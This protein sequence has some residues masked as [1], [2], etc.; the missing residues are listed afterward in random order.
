V[1]SAPDRIVAAPAASVPA[2]RAPE[3]AVVVGSDYRAL[4]IVRSLG[5]K[6]VPV[7]VLAAGDDRLAARSR[8]AA[9]SSSWPDDER[10]RVELLEELV[11]RSPHGLA[12]FSS[13]D[14]SAAWVARNHAFLGR[15][16]TLTTPSWD[17]LRWSYD[18][19]NT[20]ELA[21]EA[22]VDYPWTIYPRSRAE[23]EDLECRFPVVLKPT[24]K[25][26][27]N[28][29]TAAKAW[30]V[31]DREE[32]LR[33]YDE[34]AGLVDPDTLMV[35]EL[36]PGESDGQFSYAALTESGRVLHSIV[37][38]RTRQYPPDFGRASTFV[39]TIDDP[40]VEEP[41]R[42]LL[43]RSGFT[44]LIEV[45]YKLDPASGRMLLLDMNPR[46]WGWHT[47]GARAGVD[48][49]WLQWLQLRG[50]PAPATRAQVGVRWLRLT[51]DLPMAVRE[52]LRGRMS[53]WTYL[54]SLRPPHEGAV[55]AADDPVPGLVEVPM[56]LRTLVR[57]SLHDGPV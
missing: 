15:L 51:T 47:L 34:A 56:L 19:R 40:G 39:E 42:R 44:G 4:G 16:F 18:K 38:R 28:R 48:F 52:I 8:Y 21:L 17:V 1:V 27:S 33:R 36:I 55:F 3:G 46:V 5:R 23:L 29:F 57:R 31:D 6:G 45:E 37:A 35:Q 2:V 20:H 9:S 12:L 49:P 13:A 22:G 43:A 41:S 32:L 30:R 25:P 7:H 24:A 26:V 10:A 14:E 11:A 53:P 50:E 54:A